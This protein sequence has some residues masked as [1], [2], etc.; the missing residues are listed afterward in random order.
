MGIP[1]L[2][3]GL[4]VN[5]LISIIVEVRERCVRCAFEMRLRC[6]SVAFELREMCGYHHHHIKA[7]RALVTRGA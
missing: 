2:D 4:F 5:L 7:F 1:P 3:D 6:V